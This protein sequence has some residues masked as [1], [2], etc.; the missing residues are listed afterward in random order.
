MLR[1]PIGAA[2][3]NAPSRAVVSPVIVV[4]LGVLLLVM[5]VTLYSVPRGIETIEN[6]IGARVATIASRHAGEVRADVHHQSVT[7][8]GLVPDATTRTRLVDE[9]MALA[10]VRNVADELT[11]ASKVA[12]SRPQAYLFDAVRHPDRIELS[13]FVPDDTRRA[14]LVGLARVT[15]APTRVVDRL[16]LAPDPPAEFEP[17]IKFGLAQLALVRTGTLRF[18]GRRA[19]LDG[20]IDSPEQRGQIETAVAGH[21]FAPILRL[22]YDAA[23]TARRTDCESS[24]KGALADAELRFATGSEAL[25]PGS[26]AGLDALA[27]V[28]RDCPGLALRVEGHTDSA[29]DADLNRAL[30]ERRAREVVAQLEARGVSAERIDAQGFGDARPIAD[31]ATRAGRAANRRIELVV[32]N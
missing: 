17:A 5:F 14:S 15:F 11:V 31:N 4:A 3:P 8:L 2:L 23:E 21:R 10:G 26:E 19:L 9:V 29:G 27:A 25:R 20:V 22:R 16:V 1:R 28:I 18:N 32:V 24:M 6:D 7:L 13:G 12:R 30:S